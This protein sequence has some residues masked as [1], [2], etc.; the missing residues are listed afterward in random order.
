MKFTAEDFRKVTTIINE[1]TADKIIPVFLYPFQ[2][3]CITEGLPV[4][5]EVFLKKYNS[6]YKMNHT[7]KS[8]EHIPLSLMHTFMM[9]TWFFLHMMP[10]VESIVPSLLKMMNWDTRHLGGNLERVFA[11]CISF[12]IIE[13][14]FRQLVQLHGVQH[15][16]SQHS[17]DVLRGIKEGCVK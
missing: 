2:A 17:A 16:E 14:K 8:I 4:W 3:L 10:F 9:P 15:I 13:G 6:F 1:D 7:F 12:G 11:L 5:E